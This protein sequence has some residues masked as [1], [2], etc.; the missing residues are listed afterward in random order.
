MLYAVLK[1]RFGRSYKGGKNRVFMVCPRFLG[2]RRFFVVGA[3][4]SRSSLK[5]RGEGKGPPARPEVGF[6]PGDDDVSSGMEGEA[7]HF[8]SKWK[9]ETK[10]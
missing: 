6:L 1:S 9:I 2:R 10:R 8:G 3:S 7:P 4:P 5:G